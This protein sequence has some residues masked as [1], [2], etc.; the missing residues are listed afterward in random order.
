MVLIREVPKQGLTLMPSN[1]DRARSGRRARRV[2][3]ALMD[4]TSEYSRILAMRLVREI[5]CR[6]R[7]K[8]HRSVLECYLSPPSLLLPACSVSLDN[9]PGSH[10]FLNLESPFLLLNQSVYY[11]I[12]IIHNDGLYIFTN[13]RYSLP[14][15][16]CY[17]PH[18]PTDSSLLQLDP[19]YFHNLFLEDPV[20]FIRVAYRSTDI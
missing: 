2:R 18:P 15:I 14:M 20:S 6:Q 19:F 10:L 4:A 11:C 3:R 12:L 17:L 8:Q 16:P 1:R 13:T 7:P 9:C 5:W